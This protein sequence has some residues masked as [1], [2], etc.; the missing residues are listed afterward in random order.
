[1]LITCMLMFVISTIFVSCYTYETVTKYRYECVED[2][3]NRAYKGC[4]RTQ[5]INQ[6]GVPDRVVPIEGQAVVLVYES[7]S[8]RKPVDPLGLGIGSYKYERDWYT[9]FYMSNDGLCYLV[10]TNRIRA[11]PYQETI[12]K[13]FFE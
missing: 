13:N 6:F 2:D 4:S 12:K 7:Y 9:E 11:I 10:K 1:M 3:F 8:V 5:I